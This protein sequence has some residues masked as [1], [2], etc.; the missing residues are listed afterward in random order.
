MAGIILNIRQS[1]ICGQARE[2]AKTQL[3]AKDN[4]IGSVYIYICKGKILQLDGKPYQ[5]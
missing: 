3:V 2:I 1:K 4:T 5:P